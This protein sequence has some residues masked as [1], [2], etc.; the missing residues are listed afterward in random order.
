[1]EHITSGNAR[2]RD[3]ELHN[4]FRNWDPSRLYDSGVLS[5]GINM[6]EYDALRTCVVDLEDLDW[7]KHS[8]VIGRIMTMP[9]D[10]LPQALVKFKNLYNTAQSYANPMFNSCLTPDQQRKI[11]Y[12]EAWADDAIRKI[13]RRINEAYGKKNPEE[14][15]WIVQHQTCNENWINENGD[16][17]PLKW[18]C[19]GNF[20]TE[21]QAKH[22]MYT[23][24][25]D[26]Y[27]SAMSTADLSLSAWDWVKNVNDHADRN[28]R[29]KVRL[30]IHFD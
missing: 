14:C 2:D 27:L 12:A 21:Y 29:Y 15:T 9:R 5:Y 13:T 7:S 4:V 8:I 30:S 1:M 20:D 10:E 18:H 23:K 25:Y 19:V 22:F 3:I 6:G 16:S 17:V 24:I 26:S 11:L 28:Y